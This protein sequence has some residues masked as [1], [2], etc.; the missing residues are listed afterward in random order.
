MYRTG[1]YRSPG[2]QRRPRNDAFARLP[3]EQRAAWF[4]R[5]ADAAEASA[6]EL[7]KSGLPSGLSP[8][9]KAW[10]QHSDS[11]RALRSRATDLRAKAHAARAEVE[12]R[13]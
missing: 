7:E 5:K 2:P 11:I 8:S 6:R 9:A 4:D 3:A 13:A 1:L 12:V 10:A